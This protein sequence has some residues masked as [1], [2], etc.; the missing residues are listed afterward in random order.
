MQGKTV[1]SCDLQRILTG[2]RGARSTTQNGVW[3]RQVPRPVF[4][5]LQTPAGG[6]RRIEEITKTHLQQAAR[7]RIDLLPKGHALS[8]SAQAPRGCC[9]GPGGCCPDSAGGLLRS[10]VRI[11]SIQSKYASTSLSGIPSP[12][13]ISIA[14]SRSHFEPLC[15]NRI[16]A[17]SCAIICRPLRLP[18]AS[19]REYSTSDAASSTANRMMKRWRSR[20]ARV[21]MH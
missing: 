12:I 20:C 19:V 16:L 17:I 13:A 15:S 14:R 9:S 18:P 7:A 11:R 3:L 5:R 6:R 1:G 10:I 2:L 4:F 8:R 21:K